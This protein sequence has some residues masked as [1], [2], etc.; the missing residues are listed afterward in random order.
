MLLARYSRVMVVED[1]RYDYYSRQNA[2]SLSKTTN[3]L[4]IKHLI[5]D[6]ARRYVKRAFAT[7]LSSRGHLGD[8]SASCDFRDLQSQIRGCT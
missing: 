8:G 5:Y 1:H 7:V 6:M 3:P 2:V 4:P